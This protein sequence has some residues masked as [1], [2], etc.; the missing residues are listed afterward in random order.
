M[1]GAIA[2]GHPL[3]AEAGARVLRDGGN[4]VDALLAAAFT[5]FVTEGPLT[6]P[7]GGGFALVHE[8]DGE[9]TMLDCFFG[10][11]A[12]RLG[13]M[14]ELA[15]RLRRLGDAGV[16]RRPG[17]GRGPR[18]A[19]GSR[20]DPSAL[21]DARVE[22]PRRAGRRARSGGI[23]A[24]RAARRS[25]TGSSKAS[26]CA[27]RAGGASTATRRASDGGLR[28]RRSSACATPAP[29]RSRE[30]L[31]EYADDLRAYRVLESTPLEARGPRAHESARRR[32]RAARSS[33]AS[34]SCSAAA[35]EP[36]PRGRGAR[37]R[38]CLRRP[39]L[40]AAARARR[41]SRSIDG[42]A[43]RRRSRRRS[44]RGRASFAAARS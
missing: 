16:P 35:G 18:A 8:P 33:S 14:E 40:G 30:L 17:L 24:R 25:C 41:T 7:A 23:R 1:R 15:H 37:R 5:A 13:E 32:R 39:R 34:S 11:P 38:R 26:S 9:T 6:G 21:R 22:R 4:A 28:A 19:R 3:T 10:V 42:R 2:A 20:G 36:T 31:P 12:A 27:T 43:W 44:A 29:R